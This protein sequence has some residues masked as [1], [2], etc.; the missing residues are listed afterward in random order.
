[1]CVVRS[2]ATHGYT[3]WAEV[4]QSEVFDAVHGAERDP[5]L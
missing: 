3:R 5:A 4:T 1:M 2:L